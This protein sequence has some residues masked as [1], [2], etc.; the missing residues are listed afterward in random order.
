MPN[1]YGNP[2]P[3]ERMCLKCGRPFLSKGAGNRI[4]PDCDRH[5]EL[6]RLPPLRARGHAFLKPGVALA[7]NDEVSARYLGTVGGGKG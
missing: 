7:W 5:N 1:R 3:V 2:A 4:C 6:A